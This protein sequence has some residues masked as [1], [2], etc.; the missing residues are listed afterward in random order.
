MEWALESLSHKTT[1]TRTKLWNVYCFAP[2]Q[3]GSEIVKVNHQTT[4]WIS[5]NSIRNNKLDFP[6]KTNLQF[7]C[8]FSK[9]IVFFL[10]QHM[11]KQRR[12]MNE[13]LPKLYVESSRKLQPM[14]GKFPGIVSTFPECKP[15]NG[16][17]K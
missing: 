5:H 17:S 2:N 13:I 10:F 4:K 12:N 15:L 16:H 7:H 6:F 1:N 14:V 8:Y 11:Y 9:K 3:M